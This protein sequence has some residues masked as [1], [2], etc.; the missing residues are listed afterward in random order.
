MKTRNASALF[1]LTA[2]LAAGPAL[3]APVGTAKSLGDYRPFWQSQ[4]G[5]TSPSYQSYARPVCVRTAPAAPTPAAVAPAP[6]PAPA[7]AVAQAPSGGRRFSYEPS[8]ATTGG[9]TA[10]AVAPV[11]VMAPAAPAHAYRHAHRT[12]RHATVNR[13]A[14]PKTDARKYTT[15]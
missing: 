7:P 15:N 4:F 1:A 11:N 3:A 8:T 5:S 13:W 12:A 14:L 2:W 10:A 6:A 9:A